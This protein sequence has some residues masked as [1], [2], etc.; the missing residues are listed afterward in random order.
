MEGKQLALWSLVLGIIGVVFALMNF[1]FLIPFVGRICFCS[2]TI[3]GSLVALGAIVLGI[4]A[5]VQGAGE[6]RTRAIIGI[7]LGGLF[8]IIWIII[9]VIVQLID[10]GMSLAGWF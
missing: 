1:T 7:V 10:I 6:G 8:W 2:F 3:V 5:L 9:L 4:I